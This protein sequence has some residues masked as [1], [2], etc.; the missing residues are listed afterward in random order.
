M[1]ST[2][3]E[4][5]E[6]LF[7]RIGMQALTVMLQNNLLLVVNLTLV[8]RCCLNNTAQKQQVRR[9]DK[10]IKHLILQQPT[11]P[12]LRPLTALCADILRTASPPQQVY[13]SLQE[14]MKLSNQISLWSNASSGPLWNSQKH[15]FAGSRHTAAHNVPERLYTLGSLSDQTG[16]RSRQ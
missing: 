6:P 10:A 11:L 4:V 8:D 9:I 12:V 3:K 16:C 7:L 13:I 2:L 1:K 15:L 14:A 5:H